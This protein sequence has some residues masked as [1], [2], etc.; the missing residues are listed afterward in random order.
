MRGM[1]A[2]P[3]REALREPGLAP[4]RVDLCRDGSAA[5]R[6]AQGLFVRGAG[7]AV[8]SKGVEYGA[9]REV[10]AY[11]ERVD[12]RRPVDCGQRPLVQAEVPEGLAALPVGCRDAGRQ[13]CG[14]CERGKCPSV[15][16]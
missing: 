1:R 5:W 2:C 4:H 7:L 11:D 9:A 8:P 6:E 15:P 10:G 12:G 14:L 13:G 3:R 16:I